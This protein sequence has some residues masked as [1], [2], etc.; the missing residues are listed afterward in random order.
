MYGQCGWWRRGALIV[1][2]VSGLACNGAIHDPSAQSGAAGGGK[3]PHADAIPRQ[4]RQHAGRAFACAPGNP[5]AIT[6]LVRLTHH[7]Y[8]NTI[9]DLTG[10]DLK[11]ASSFLADQHQ[12]GFDRG[13]DLQVGDVLATA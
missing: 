7:Q 1:G 6:R 2:V 5:S 8:D 12:A 13:I 11:L 10:L 9:A 4:R 3:A